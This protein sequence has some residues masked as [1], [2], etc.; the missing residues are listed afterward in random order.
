MM[1]VAAMACVT[2][3]HGL[4]AAIPGCGADAPGMVAQD[5]AID[6]VSALPEVVALRQSLQAPMR[7][8][9]TELGREKV[10]GRCGTSVP[11]YVDHPERFELRYVFFVD[12]ARGEVTHALDADGGYVPLAA[13]RQANAAR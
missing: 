2:S 5:K 12:D 9:F 13:W 4:A 7:V 10:S 11:V 8:A 3:G 1:L 6:R